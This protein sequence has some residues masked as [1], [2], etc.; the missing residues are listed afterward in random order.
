MK[1]YVSLCLLITA[2]LL[3]GQP[4]KTVAPDTLA[5]KPSDTVI[6]LS[7]GKTVFDSALTDQARIYA[8][9]LPFNPTRYARLTSTKVWA[10]HRKLFEE[11]WGKLDKR[12]Q[13]MTQWRKTELAGISQTG[14]T[15]FYPFRR[16]R[17]SQ[18]R[19]LLPGLRKFHLHQ[20]RKTRRNPEDRHEREGLLEFSR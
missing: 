13:A 16:A 8:G 14:A 20:P 6:P 4:V 3:F 15:L 1:K 18:C 7:F 17:F 12:L 2:S 11:N 5:A 10:A 9:M 19:R